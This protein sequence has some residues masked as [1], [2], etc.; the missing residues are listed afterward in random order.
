MPKWIPPLLILFVVFFILNNPGEAGPQTRSFFS[1]IGD[2][3]GNA[4]TFLDGLF[5]EEAVP[6]DPANPA[7]PAP[8]TGTGNTEDTFSTMPPTLQ[9]LVISATV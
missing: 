2:Q 8:T 3:A 1:W 9:P 6:T 5:G 7:T 4:G